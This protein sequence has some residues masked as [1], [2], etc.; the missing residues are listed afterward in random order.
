MPGELND[1]YKENDMSSE[2]FQGRVAI[3]TGGASGIGEATCR[4][5]VAEGG[6]VVVADRNIAAARAL[7]GELGSQ[8]LPVEFDAGDVVSIEALVKATL[9]HF[10]RLDILHNNA[11]IGSPEVH[12]RDTNAVDIDFETWDLVMAVNLRGYLAACKFALPH[13]LE[14]GSGVIVNSASAGGFAGDISRIAYTVSKTAIIG[15]TRQ[16]AS[17]HGRQGI[18]CNA[19]APGLVLT[20]AARAVAGDV[21]EVMGR[22][23][24]TPE[25]GDGNDIANLVCFLASDEARYIN[26]QTYVIDGGML[27][28]NPANPDLEEWAART[29]QS[30]QAH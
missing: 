18:R 7:A 11:A 1:S 4:R 14:R 8:S 27:A 28:H 29:R 9:E 16:I 12:A 26:G 10:G 17:Q 5:L 23:I 2:R 6:R 21:I 19:V 13:M 3:V 25:F 24:L 30:G 20:P 22:H 15:L